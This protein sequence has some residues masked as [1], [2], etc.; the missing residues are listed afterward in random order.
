MKAKNQQV[1]S[2]KFTCKVKDSH[3]WSKDKKGKITVCS[4]S[5]SQLALYKLSMYASIIENYLDLDEWTDSY[6]SFNSL[7]LNLRI[8]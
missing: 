5:P 1:N 6:Y 3:C 2:I 7:L 4:W 8:T